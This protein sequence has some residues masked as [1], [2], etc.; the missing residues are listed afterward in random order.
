M[1]ELLHYRNF[2]DARTVTGT[3]RPPFNEPLR[4]R[5]DRQAK[6]H[7]QVFFACCRGEENSIEDLI[8]LAYR[9]RK[10]TWHTGKVS[11]RSQ[12]LWMPELAHHIRRYHRFHS[13][14]IAAPRIM[15]RVGPSLRML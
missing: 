8:S 4:N 7:G 11:Q 13:P 6:D 1:L 15:L 3:S 10:S 2:P 12:Q 5:D 9:I 14:P